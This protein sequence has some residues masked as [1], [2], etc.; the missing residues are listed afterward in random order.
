VRPPVPAAG[1]TLALAA[2]V[3]GT[4]P[5]LVCLHGFA[6]TRYTWRHLVEPLA[7]RATVIRLDLKGFGDSPKPRDGAYALADHAAAVTAYLRAHD[8]RDVTL[9]GHSFG[10]IVA[11]AVTLGLPDGDSDRIRALVLIGTPGPPQPLPDFI[12]A[13]RTRGLGPLAFHALPARV[14]V[15]RVLARIYHDRRRIPPDVVTAYARILRTPGTGRALAQT[16][17]HLDPAALDGLLQ[18]SAAIRVPTLCV[19]GR[20]DRL[21]PLAAGECL[22]RALP[23]ARLV[24]ID[25][26]GHGPQEETPVAVVAALAG[27]LDELDRGGARRPDPATASPRRPA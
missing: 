26:A 16:A 21:G 4:G 20:H 17:G 14:L 18:Q 12:R 13:L 8:L 6:A 27:F 19:W 23:D 9:V 25:D 7:R 10:G 11:R 22:A 2:D 24:V 3:T 5:P 15:R 1:P